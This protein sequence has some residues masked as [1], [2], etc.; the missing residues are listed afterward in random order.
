VSDIAWP[1]IHIIACIPVAGGMEPEMVRSMQGV[2]QDLAA[3]GVRFSWC[4]DRAP[5]TGMARDSMMY[6]MLTETDATHHLAWDADVEVLDP[7]MVARMVE[8]DVDMVG[9]A[10]LGKDARNVPATFMVRGDEMDFARQT[11]VAG[12]I[13]ATYLAGG[14]I[15][16]KRAALARMRE[17]YAAECGYR[18][19]TDPNAPPSDEV[20]VGLCDDL[21]L[22]N[23]NRLLED[24]AFSERAARIGI[25]RWLLL[26][27]PLTHHGRGAYGWTGNYADKWRGMRALAVR[28]GT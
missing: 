7:T 6:T 19:P 16:T 1:T 5:T 18:P 12:A 13:R 17:H 22:D 14:M 26:D 28:C 25:E 4:F 2:A 24:Y 8:C 15:L 9:A 3:R 21:V 10:Y 27:A 11:P 23:G 20:L